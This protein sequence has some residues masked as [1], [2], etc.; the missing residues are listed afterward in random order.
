MWS[1]INVLHHVIIV[2]AVRSPMVLA[3]LYN[4]HV[5]TNAHNFIANNLHKAV[6]LLFKRVLFI[7]WG[8]ILLMIRY[9]VKS[10]IRDK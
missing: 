9:A 7:M 2:Y 3:S 8:N 10:K 1:K 6:Y 5:Y 4:L